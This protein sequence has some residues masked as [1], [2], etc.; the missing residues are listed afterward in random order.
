MPTDLGEPLGLVVA[1]RGGSSNLIHVS[2]VLW[3]PVAEKKQE[4]LALWGV[5]LSQRR[6]DRLSF[7][8]PWGRPLPLG[9]ANLLCRDLSFKG[10]AHFCV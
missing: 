6:Q 5:G 3:K 7:T 9:N 4:M 1:R 10:A 8:V 2:T